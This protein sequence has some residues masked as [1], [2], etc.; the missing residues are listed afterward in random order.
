MYVQNCFSTYWLRNTENFAFRPS[1]DES[2]VKFA[3]ISLG[4]S[5]SGL[6]GCFFVQGDA[7]H[8]AGDIIKAVYEMKLMAQ[9]WVHQRGKF[10]G[11]QR[12]KSLLYK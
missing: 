7:H 1:P 4:K 11:K 2:Q 9:L 6:F 8:P 5:I 12:L 10:L 3:D